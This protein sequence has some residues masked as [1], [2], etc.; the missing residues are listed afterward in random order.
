MGKEYIDPGQNVTSPK[1]GLAS[2]ISEGGI[3][4]S[5]NVDQK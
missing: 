1:I 4:A 5:V 2:L 3:I